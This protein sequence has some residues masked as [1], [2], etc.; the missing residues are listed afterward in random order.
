M[1]GQIFVMFLFSNDDISEQ[2]KDY[3]NRHLAQNVSFQVRPL[4]PETFFR[5]KPGDPARLLWMKAEGDI[6][7]SEHTQEKW[8]GH[9]NCTLPSI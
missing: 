1:H 5:Q 8:L 2:E 3:I 4:D 7:M 6:G 9:E